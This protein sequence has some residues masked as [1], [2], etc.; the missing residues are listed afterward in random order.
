MLVIKYSQLYF[1]LCWILDLQ[2]LLMTPDLASLAH[3]F[4]LHSYFLCSCPTTHS[5][6]DDDLGLI[7]IIYFSITY[8]F[9]SVT[10]DDVGDGA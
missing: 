8:L 2:L 7:M 6:P 5:I 9:C 4:L 3:T 10:G 1:S